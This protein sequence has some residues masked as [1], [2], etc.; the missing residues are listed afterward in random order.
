VAP[1]LSV[2]APTAVSD[3]AAPAAETLPTAML[4]EVVVLAVT[5]L[6]PPAVTELSV[7]S[8]PAAKSVIAPLLVLAEVTANAPLLLMSIAPVPVTFAEVSVPIV[9]SRSM[10]VP[11]EAVRLEAVTLFVA[12]LLSVIAPTAVSDTAAPAAETLP[13]AMLPGGV[14][15]SVPPSPP[16]AVTEL[17]VRSPP[18]A[19][20][21]IAP[22]LVLAEVTANAPLLLMSIAPVPVTFAEVSVPIV[23]SRSMPVPAEAVRLEAVT[24]FVAPLLS[25]IAP[26]A[27]SDTAAPAAET[28]PTAML[29]EVVVL[30]VTP[31]PPPAVTELSVRSPPAAKSVIAPLLVLAEVTA[32]APLLLMSIA[33]VPVTFAEVSVPIVVSRSMP[34]PAEAVRLEAVTLFV[35]PLLSVIAPTAVSTTAAPAAE[36]LPTAMLPEVVVLAVTPLPPPAVTE[37][38]VRSPPAAKSVIAPLLVLAEVTANAPLLLMSIA[39]VPVTF[40]ASVP[41]AVNIGAPE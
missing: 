1:L 8:P 18:A 26:T 37:L 29:P 34:V 2:I 27:V 12:P 31:L 5:P 25:V 39:P 24:L 13:T 40:A 4:P 15:L 9:V 20:S 30:A 17:S 6:P 36:T 28:L 11:A 33:P 10:P 7:R 22:L 41:V 16:P 38:S 35:A 21:V 23:V 14:G 32:N 19:K 3:T